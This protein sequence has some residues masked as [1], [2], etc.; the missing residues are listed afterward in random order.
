LNQDQLDV[1]WDIGFQLADL[2]H[3]IYTGG[4]RGADQAYARGVNAKHPELLVWVLPWW[5]S[6]DKSLLKPDNKVITLKGANGAYTEAA[7]YHP[8]WNSL[9]HQQQR[10]LARNALLVSKVDAMIAW[11]NRSKSGWGGT[12][13]AMRC[14]EGIP[15]FDISATVWKTLRVEDILREVTNE[16][17]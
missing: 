10:P 7:R 17:V 2:G 3:E 4:A 12:G 1:C 9:S 8:V 13:H 15:V 14:A 16:R 5:A 6:F 11:P